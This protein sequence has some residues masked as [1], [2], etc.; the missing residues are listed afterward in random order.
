MKA[1]HS[2]KQQK[3]KKKGL[4]KTIKL[5]WSMEGRKNTK[6]TCQGEGNKVSVLQLKPLLPVITQP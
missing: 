5:N 4:I 1:K 3:E 6:G 2:R